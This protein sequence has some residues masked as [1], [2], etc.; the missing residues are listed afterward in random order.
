MIFPAVEYD[1]GASLHLSKCTSKPTHR[2]AMEKG[3]GINPPIF[4]FEI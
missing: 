1:A 3:R 2:H 4:K